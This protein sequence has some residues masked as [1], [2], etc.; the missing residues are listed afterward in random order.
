VNTGTSPNFGSA[1]TWSA[2]L[3]LSNSRCK[4]C[5]SGNCGS[6]SGT[7]AAPG[8]LLLPRP[9]CMCLPVLYVPGC[10]CLGP[11]SA[12][13][14]SVIT[15]LLIPTC[16]AKAP[17]TMLPCVCF[18]LASV[19]STSDVSLAC[20]SGLLSIA[21]RSVLVCTFL[22]SSCCSCCEP[23]CCG[24]CWLSSCCCSCCSCCWSPCLS[25]TAGGTLLHC[26][27]GSGMPIATRWYDC[28]H[29]LHSKNNTVNQTARRSL[30]GPNHTSHSMHTSKV[31]IT[32]ACIPAWVWLL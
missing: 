3:Q 12:A 19:S 24:D 25:G 7:D 28:K 27:E 5:G 17:A 18:A 4:R 20:L 31:Q 30:Q 10:A 22:S 29:S 16:P 1:Q 11:T 14:A 23:S 13:P 8:M 2:H 6:G 15:A 26:A 9:G 21:L 32:P